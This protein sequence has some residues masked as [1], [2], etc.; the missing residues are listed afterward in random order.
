MIQNMIEMRSLRLILTL[1]VILVTVPMASVFGGLSSFNPYYW[2][3]G[4]SS[5]G[6][7]FECAS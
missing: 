1:A 5:F 4:C 3:H 6:A 7:R 2:N